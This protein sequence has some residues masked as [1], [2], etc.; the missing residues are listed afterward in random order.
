MEIILSSIKKPSKMFIGLSGLYL[1]WFNIL[2]A[3]YE[4]SPKTGFV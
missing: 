1:W 4:N 3:E 2:S